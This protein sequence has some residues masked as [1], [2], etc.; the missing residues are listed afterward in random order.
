MNS[1][2]HR[3]TDLDALIDQVHQLF[4]RW[5]QEQT[6]APVIGQD[7][8]CQLK[9][10]VHEWVANLIQHAS[11]HQDPPEVTIT[12]R[13][14]EAQ[15]ECAI[16]DNSEGFDLGAHLGTSLKVFET[17]PERGMG[18]LILKSCVEDLSYTQNDHGYNRLD[19]S[20]SGD[21]YS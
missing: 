3:F 14:D 10:A 1:E 2:T 16:Q 19:F 7:T 6:F 21:Q 11:F 18:L 8:L 9:L 17:F 13:A 12:V 4:L 20:V 15:V 5:E